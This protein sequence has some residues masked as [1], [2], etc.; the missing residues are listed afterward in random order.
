MF[1][2]MKTKNWTTNKNVTQVPTLKT[3]PE[4]FSIDF[5][6][7]SQLHYFKTTYKLYRQPQS[8]MNLCV[9]WR[10]TS[11]WS[12]YI[13]YK[14]LIRQIRLNWRAIRYCFQ[15]DYKA[16]IH[17]IPST[18]NQLMFIVWTGSQVF[19]GNL[20]LSFCTD[21]PSLRWWKDAI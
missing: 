19:L 8:H 10:Y 4:I 6:N 11:F 16:S 21:T 5:L 3:L 12:K 20:V 7:Y 15:K 1:V 13:K 17:L 14:C 2:W 18:T 9:K